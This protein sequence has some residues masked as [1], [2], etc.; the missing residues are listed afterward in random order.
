MAHSRDQSLRSW[1][2]KPF[3]ARAWG[4]GDYLAIVDT[5]AGTR[6]A[7]FASAPAA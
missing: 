7:M 5:M 4:D 1:R 3:Q 6:G 2:G